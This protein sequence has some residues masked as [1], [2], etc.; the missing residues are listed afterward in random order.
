MERVWMKELRKEKGLTLKKLG[1]AVGLSECYLFRIEQGERK[2][3]GMDTALL[4]KMAAA[5]KEKPM[6]LLR[7]EMAWCEEVADG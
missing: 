4:C 6:K 2:L 5:L 7:A 3:D 1:E